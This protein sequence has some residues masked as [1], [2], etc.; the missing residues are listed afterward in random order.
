MADRLEDFGAAILDPDLPVPEGIVGPDGLPSPRRFAVY[1]NNV[2][3][4]L[5]DT[6]LAAYPVVARLVGVEFFRAMAR[7]YVAAHQPTS[8]IMLDYGAGFADFVELFAP[9]RSL[10]YLADVARLERGWVEAYHSAEALALTADDLATAIPPERFGDTILILHP[11]FRLLRSRYP[12]VAIWGMNIAGA[13]PTPVD[14]GVAEDAL[15]VRPGAEVEVRTLPTKGEAEFLSALDRGRRV[16][17][18]ALEALGVNPRFD[19]V[20]SLVGLL[21]FGLIVDW[22]LVDELELSRNGA[23]DVLSGR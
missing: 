12:I 23:S 4:G 18:A 20:S 7:S 8:P 19:L 14:L 13:V 5:I 21:S 3:V 9:A 11:S 2:V 15:V 16:S 1:R 6:L 10:P 22:R 17:D